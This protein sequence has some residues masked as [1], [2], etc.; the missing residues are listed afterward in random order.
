PGADD[1]GTADVDHVQLRR[2]MD[3]DGA[4]YPDLHARVR[5]DRRWN[6]LGTS[7]ADDSPRQ[8]DRAGAHSFELA[9]RHQTRH[10]L[11]RLR[12]SSVRHARFECP[13]V[14]AR[15]RGV[16]LVRHSGV[17]RRSGTPRFLSLA[18]EWLA[19]GDSRHDRRPYADR[20]DLF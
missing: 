17:D 15:A 7:A 5:A 20:V 9:R 4:L 8:Y 1:S 14:D 3:F 2:V 12:A 13:R 11:P 6:E 16:R 10:S 18:V 19:H